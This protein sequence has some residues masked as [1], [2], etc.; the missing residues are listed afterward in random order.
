MLDDPTAVDAFI[1]YT[2]GGDPTASTKAARLRARKGSHFVFADPTGYLVASGKE[3]PTAVVRR[4]QDV[5][6]FKVSP[7]TNLQ[8]A[9]LTVD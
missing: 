5:G 4:S 8:R 3:R 7:L 6:S 9:L 1:L 2:A